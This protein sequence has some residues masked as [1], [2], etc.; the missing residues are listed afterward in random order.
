MAF[1]GDFLMMSDSTPAR[2]I[3]TP[4]GWAV[5]WIPGRWLDRN[6][7]ITSITIAE[8]IAEGVTPGH[9]LWPHVLSWLAEIGL[10]VNDMPTVRGGSW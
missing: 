6:G 1:I 3:R 10:T 2:C 8:F 7:A 9:R 5:S 4:D